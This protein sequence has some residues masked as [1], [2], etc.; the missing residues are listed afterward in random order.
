MFWR[1]LGCWLFGHLPEPDSDPMRAMSFYTVCHY[2]G[3]RQRVTR[4]Q[5][6]LT[7]V[8]LRDGE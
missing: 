8:D 3:K 4:Q 6:R 7:F 5:G 2:C 1:R